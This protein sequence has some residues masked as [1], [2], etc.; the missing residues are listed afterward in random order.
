MTQ[1]AGMRNQEGDDQDKREWRDPGRDA[2]FEDGEVGVDAILLHR[3]IRQEQEDPNAGSYRSAIKMEDIA[4]EKG[5]QAAWEE[6]EGAGE[7]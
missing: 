4:F 3:L 2:V 7:E 1:E 6:A 5:V